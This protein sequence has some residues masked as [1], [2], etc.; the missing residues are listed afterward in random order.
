VTLQVWEDLQCPICAQYDL[1]VEPVLVQKYVTPGTLRIIHHDIAILG[2]GGADD[3]SKLAAAGA[4]CAQ[5]EGRYWDYVHWVYANQ[6]G[7]N[8][9]AFMRDSLASIAE[10]AGVDRATFLAC[11]DAQATV[12]TVADTT[13][14]A[15]NQ[16]INQT[17]TMNLNGK[18]L[19]GL[20]SADALGQ[21]I[22]QAAAASPAASGSSPAA[23]S[24]SAAASAAP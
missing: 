13:T 22:E 23:A 19:V 20:R 17:P 3:E 1:N 12:Q 9:G 4:T 11:I 10:S 14:Q 2:R 18:Q 6:D 5:N 8:A 21:L 24:P 7:E 15:L 16:G